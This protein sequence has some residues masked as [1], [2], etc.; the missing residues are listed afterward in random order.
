[1]DWHVRALGEREGT[2][3]SSGVEKAASRSKKSVFFLKSFGCLCVEKD[4]KTRVYGTT[5]KYVENK[6]F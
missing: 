4:S 1:M 3:F 6:P 2:A 5:G